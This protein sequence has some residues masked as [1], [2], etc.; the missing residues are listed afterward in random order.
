[1]VMS[2]GKTRLIGLAYSKNLV[3]M[4]PRNLRRV[5][6]PPI[7]PNCLKPSNRPE[8]I[9]TSKTYREGGQS[10]QLNVEVHFAAHPDCTSGWL[11]RNIS[12]SVSIRLESY[13]RL[14]FIFREPLYTTLFITLN[15]PLLY[16]D[17][18]TSL[19]SSIR[20]I[21][22][23]RQSNLKRIQKVE[24]GRCKS[25]I[26]IT[27]REPKPATCPSCSLELDYKYQELRYNKDIGIKE[28]DSLPVDVKICP[29]CS[30]AMIPD[31]EL[32]ICGNCSHSLK[33]V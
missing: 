22:Y 29:N 23:L 21:E 7:C 5:Q 32:T 10:R 16:S 28:K 1:M 6:I 31:S 12:G 27:P 9:K 3:K 2:I 26:L 18:G 25:E 11:N 30:I 24:C 33:E 13:D 20:E 14:V 8:K 15:F 17:R 4:D 19:Q